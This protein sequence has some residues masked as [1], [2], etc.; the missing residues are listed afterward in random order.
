MRA[1][2]CVPGPRRETESERRSLWQRETDAVGLSGVD[3]R[4]QLLGPAGVAQL[5]QGLGLDLADAL[6][7]HVEL[8]PHLLEGCL[9]Y[10][11]P[12]PRDA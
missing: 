10:T 7:R 6:A 4:L 9:L 2:L 5:A 11:S 8:A 12:S 1:G 3:E